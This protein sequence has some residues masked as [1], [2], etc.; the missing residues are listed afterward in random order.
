MHWSC[1]Y[2]DLGVALRLWR[3]VRCMRLLFG[4]VYDS[5]EDESTT[6][7][8][9]CQG[10]RDGAYANTGFTETDLHMST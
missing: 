4:M 8:C 7:T 10:T 2:E 1:H 9:W 6:R 3:T 5:S